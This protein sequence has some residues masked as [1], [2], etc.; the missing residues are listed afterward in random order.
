VSVRIRVVPIL[1]LLAVACHSGKSGQPG[2][3]P[4]PTPQTHLTVVNQA[5]LDMDIY[6]LP[7]DGARVRL[8]TAT[9]NATQTFRI[10][11][12]L[13]RTPIT[14]R[15]LCVPI[16]G[17]HSPVSQSVSVSPGDDVELQIPPA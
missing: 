6:V 8:G 4:E 1:L 17:N 2:D 14:M 7:Q 5:F 16:G 13:V 9:G 10:P 12:F 15:F 3:Q 11:D